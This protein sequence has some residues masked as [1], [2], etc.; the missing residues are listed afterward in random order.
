MDKMDPSYKDRM[1]KLADKKARKKGSKDPD[2]QPGFN[3]RPFMEK[4]K[5]KSKGGKK[6]FKPRT[7]DIKPGMTKNLPARLKKM[8]DK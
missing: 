5:D 3:P 1:R 2:A 6:K 7:L 8:K 4:I